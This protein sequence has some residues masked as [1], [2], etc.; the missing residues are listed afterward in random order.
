VT[1]LWD[2]TLW[3]H[4]ATGFAALFAG[5]GAL[6][7]RK[8][9]RRHRL[10]GRGY[11]YSMAFVSASAVALYAIQPSFTRLLLGLVAVFS[12]Y[13]AFSGYRVLARKRP[14][15]A[16]DRLD[17][18]AVALFAA[19]S[20]VLAGF[21]ATLYLDGASFG[22]VVLVFGGIG[23]VFGANDLRW[24]RRGPERGEWLGEH[25]TRMG[26]GYIATVSA[27]S[28]VN[29]QFLPFVPRWLWPTLL[30]T[31]LLFYFRGK[32]EDEFGVGG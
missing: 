13:F 1:L 17:W 6:A 14:R 32:Y 11:V 20:L 12:F 5:L 27:F 18:G 23:V 26:A 31:P 22:T 15:D 4:I 8:G 24:L 2:A 19:S 7:T 10:F 30:G 28:A 25:L 16:P 29:F 9:G 21:G 3:L